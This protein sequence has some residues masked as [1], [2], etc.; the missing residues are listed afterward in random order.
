VEELCRWQHG[1]A[2]GGDGVSAGRG[3]G[4]ADL[5]V[6]AGDR[7]LGAG[8]HLHRLLHLQRTHIR[9]DPLLLERRTRRQTKGQGRI[10]VDLH[11]DLFVDLSVDAVDLFVDLSTD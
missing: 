5:H 7:R 1:S 3:V 9:T 10:V 6:G 2:V 4:G 8:T 11:V